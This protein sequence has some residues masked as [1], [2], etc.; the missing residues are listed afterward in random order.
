MTRYNTV[1]FRMEWIRSNGY[2]SETLTKHAS[3]YKNHMILDNTILKGFYYIS[4]IL[5][6]SWLPSVSI[7]SMGEILLL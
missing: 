4:D 1:F 5:D 2:R 3:I 7:V 6:S